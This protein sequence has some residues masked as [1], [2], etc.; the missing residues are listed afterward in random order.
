VVHRTPRVGILGK[1][2]KVTQKGGG[3]KKIDSKPIQGISGRNSVLD[4]KRQRRRRVEN[5]AVV[6][7]LPRQSEVTKKG[8]GTRRGKE[9]T[10]E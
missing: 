1:K 10:L 5:Q 9:V 4:T 6:E 7:N 8:F 3:V 2:R